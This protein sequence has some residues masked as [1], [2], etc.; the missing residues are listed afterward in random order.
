MLDETISSLV[1]LGTTCAAVDVLGKDN[2]TYIVAGLGATAGAVLGYMACGATDVIEE[3]TMPDPLIC[4]AGGAVAGGV[5]SGG[6]GFISGTVAE[7]INPYIKE[8]L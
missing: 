2:Y 7:A 4:G 8:R 1:S 6:F 5:I 3:N